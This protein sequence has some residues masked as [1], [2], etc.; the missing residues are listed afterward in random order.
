MRLEELTTKS[1]FLQLEARLAKCKTVILSEAVSPQDDTG[2]MLKTATKRYDAAKRGLAIAN[3]LKD[4]AQ[5]QKHQSQ[6]MSNLNTLRSMLQK[7]EKKLSAEIK[8]VDAAKG[9]LAVANKLKD[10]EQKKKHQ[11]GIMSTLNKA[12]GR[13]SRASRNMK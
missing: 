6:V 13:L 12:R 5:K 9:G 7:I 4:P 8:Q 3:K 10:P 2:D 1:Y 11:S